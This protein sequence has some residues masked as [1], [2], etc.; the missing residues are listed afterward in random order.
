MADSGT[1][2]GSNSVIPLQAPHVAL[3]G[4]S[5]I[6]GNSFGFAWYAFD[7]RL[8]YPVT[9][10]NASSLDAPLL[11][12]VDM[13]V[14]P[15]VTPAELERILGE[16]GKDRI[17]AW[18]RNGGRL[19]TLDGATSWLASPNLNLSRLRVRRDTTRA[20]SVGGAPL[21]GTIPGAIV[22]VTADTLSPLLAGVFQTEF[23]VLANSDRVYTIPKDLR[24]GEAVVRYAEAPRLRLSGYLWP[25]M[26]ERLALSPYLW[27]ERVGR[28][29]IIAFAGDPNFR[30]LWRGLLPLFANA[31]LL[32]PSF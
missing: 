29:R 21:P 11:Q 24:S 28:G 19:I 26:P 23:P 15:S 25:E 16:A 2:L 20:D 17:I 18:V 10:V 31:V 27:T 4:G 30:D 1:D 14:I 32:G 8:G 22:R 5:P 9:T 13:L 7:Q 3:V 12:N 6:S